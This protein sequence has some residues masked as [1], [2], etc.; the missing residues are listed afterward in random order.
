MNST[1]ETDDYFSRHTFTNV[2]FSGVFERIKLRSIINEALY[3]IHIFIKYGDKVYMED[4]RL[5]Q[6]VI[7][8]AEL[9]KNKYWKHFY[10]LSLM[11]TN[12]KHIVIEDIKYNSNFSYGP[13]GYPVYFEETRL[14]WIDT[15]I[16]DG[17]HIID[18]EVARTIENHGHLCYYKINPYDIANMEYTSQ[19][20]LDTFLYTYMTRRCDIHYNRFEEKAMIF[21]DLVISYNIGI[22]EK[23]LEE[24]LEYFEDKKNVINLATLYDK[25]G[26]N[27]DILMM[28]YNNILSADGNRRHKPIIINFGTHS[29]LYER[30]ARIMA[31]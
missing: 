6:I 4:Y 10:D 28:I 22:M 17:N 16:I 2:E 7:S 1:I 14:W 29:N 21:N 25:N 15:A 24:L 13:V 31:V 19:E 20:D 12:N 18:Q 8:F 11:L 23:D 9:Q 30:F 5:G 27:C 26:M 3:S